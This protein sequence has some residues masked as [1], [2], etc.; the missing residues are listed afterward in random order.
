MAENLLARDFDPSGANE[1]WSGDIT[2]IPT[3]EC[4]LYLV[5]VEDLFSRMIVGWSMAETMESRLV[6][7]ALEMA[8]PPAVPAQGS[9]RT[10]TAEASTP[11]AT[12]SGCWRPWGSCAA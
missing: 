12:T 9:W 3:R 1:S 6:V 2:Y 5:V 10:R 11:A 4:W 7:G 8:V